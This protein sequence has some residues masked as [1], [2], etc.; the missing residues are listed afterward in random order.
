MKI[1]NINIVEMHAEKIVLGIVL[2]SIMPMV[3]QF[4]KIKFAKQPQST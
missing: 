1:K 2:V 3:W 4:A